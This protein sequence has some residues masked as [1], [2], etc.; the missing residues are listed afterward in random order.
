MSSYLVEPKIPSGVIITFPV[1]GPLL[2]SWQVTAKRDLSIPPPTP[3][4]LCRSI[5]FN[6]RGH[7][8]GQ[9]DLKPNPL[10]CGS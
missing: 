10:K 6:G 5:L 7:G 4:P 8:E 9:V 1:E 3:P 2:P